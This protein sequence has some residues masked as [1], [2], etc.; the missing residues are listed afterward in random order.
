MERSVKEVRAIRY[1][2][3]MDGEQLRAGQR[4]SSAPVSLSEYI[5]PASEGTRHGSAEYKVEWL[6]PSPFL[7]EVVDFKATIGGDA[8][9]RGSTRMYLNSSARKDAD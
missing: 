8:V 4:R 2:P 7:L 1:K 6:G 3:A 5:R 9:S